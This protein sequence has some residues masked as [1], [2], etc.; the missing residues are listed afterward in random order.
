MMHTTRLASALLALFLCR[1]VDASDGAPANSELAVQQ[2]FE[3]DTLDEAWHVNNGK[4]QAVGGVLRASE[5]ESDNHAAAARYPVETENAVYQFRFRFVGDGKAFHFGFDPAPGEL[6]KRGHLFSVVVT[7][8]RMRLMKHLDKNRPKE[9]PNEMLAENSFDFSTGQW[10]TVRVSTWNE[11]V[12]VKVN[13][14]ETMTAQ[15]PTF[16]V[17]KPTLVFRC[18]GDGIEV[19]DIVVW[20]QIKS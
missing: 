16:G 19:D 9:D 8:N 15:H 4:W 17:K 7:P 10:Y 12:T 13:G 11:Y 2:T 20:R 6:D 3:S 14:N 1:S 18:L 5:I